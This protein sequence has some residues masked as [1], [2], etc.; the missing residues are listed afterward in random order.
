MVTSCIGCVT[1]H[2]IRTLPVEKPVENVVKPQKT[3]KTAFDRVKSHKVIS[4]FPPLPYRVFSFR[5]V[6]KKCGKCGLCV[7]LKF[8]K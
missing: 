8:V 7:L 2:H 5:G 3:A 6:E 1:A 4:L